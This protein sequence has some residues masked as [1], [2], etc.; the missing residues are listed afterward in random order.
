[1]KY[2]SLCLMALL[3]FSCV[4]VSQNQQRP[5]VYTKVKIESVLDRDIS[6]RA[7]NVND[8][9]IFYGCDKGEFGYLNTADHSIAYIGGVEFNGNPPE[10]R[11]IAHTGQADF[12]LSAGNPAL[13]YKVNF[14]GKRRLVHQDSTAGIFYNALA[15]WN[16]QEGL[17]LGDPV[18]NCL[19]LLIT[20]DGGDFWNPVQCSELPFYIPGEAGF[21]A[22][23]TNIHIK[24]NKAWVVTGGAAARVYFTNDKG[25]TW[26]AYDTP[27]VSGK[28]TQGIYSVDFYNEDLGVIVGGDYTQP[29]QMHNNKAITFDGGKSW[30]VIS[31]QALPGY[32]S[33]IKFIPNSGGQEMV[34]VGFTGIAYSSDFGKT[35]KQLSDEGF[36]TLSFLNEYT[37]YAAG[38]GGIKKIVFLE[39]SM[40]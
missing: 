21:A 30:Q 1:M 23:N 24:G 34:A 17:A 35:W 6:I 40:D 4:K 12:I 33:C 13:L 29:N 10:F 37:A 14:F 3:C 15:F 2:I 32:K 16:D 8:Q 22:S 36:Y 5:H 7:L 27:I 25:A 38:K 19:R 31:D 11:A 18:D 9:H 20:R 26:K 39:E 28:A